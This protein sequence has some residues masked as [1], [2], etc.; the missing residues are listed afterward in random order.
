MQES[1]PKMSGCSLR[2]RRCL[3]FSCSGVFVILALVSGLL[4]PTIVDPIMRSQLVLKPGSKNFD[5]WKETP[6]P[7]YLEL[8]LFNWTNPDDINNHDIK[9][10]FVE[11][12]PYVFYEKH[13][14][15]DL[16]WNNNK[17]VTFKQ[18]RIWNFMPDMS[19]GTLDDMVTNLNV[20][21]STVAYTVRSKHYLIQKAV[22]LLMREKREKLVIT[23][24]VR[25]LLF[26]G[27]KDPLIDLIRKMNNTGFQIPF[28]KFGW[29]YARNNSKT[30]DGEFN[31]FTGEDSMSKLGV[32]DRWNG[33][34]ETKFYQDKSQCSKVVG[35]TGELWPPIEGNGKITVFATDI[36]RG[37]SLTYSKAHSEHGVEGKLYIGDKSVFDNGVSYPENRCY[38]MSDQAH[39][40]DL[41]PGMLNVSSCRYGAPAFVSYPHFYLSDQS[42]LEAVDGLKPDKTLHEFRVALEPQTGIPLLVNARLQINMLLQPMKGISMLNNVPKVFV[43]MMWFCQRVSL[44]EDLASEA[45]LG[46]VMIDLG[47]YLSYAFAGV[48]LLIII[49][50]L[51]LVCKGPWKGSEGERLIRP[52]SS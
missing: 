33:V 12:G 20:I 52:V 30:Y 31:M 2:C 3:L 15:V 24:S 25:E 8:Y 29:F 21:V 18:R 27:Y 41:E 5:M 1:K 38:C 19:T 9:P 49:I 36:C 37:V 16:N 34:T 43:P 39:C 35:T 11:M 50:G 17:T 48:A 44:T 14:R 22:D 10:H 40:P 42:Y 4:W 51:Y 45:K 47:Y 7:I 32:L 46:L 6:I 23:K 13:V 26:D 28:D